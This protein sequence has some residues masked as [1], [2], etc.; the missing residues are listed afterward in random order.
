MICV[1][2]AAVVFWDIRTFTKVVAF[3]ANG[4]SDLEFGPGK[5]N[6]S[7]DGRYI[8]VRAR[9][10][11]KVPVAFVIDLATGTKFSDIDLSFLPGNNNYVSVSPTGRY[12]FAYQ[13]T[14][15]GDQGHI[16]TRDGI[17]VQH[18]LEHHRPGHGDMT[19]DA[20]G[21]DVM[22]GISKSDPDKYHVIKRRLRDGKVTDL[23]PGCRTLAQHVS[24]RNIR[25]PGWVFVT[26][27]GDKDYRSRSG[28]YPFYQSIAMLR[29]DGS[30]EISPVAQTRSI[31]AG[32]YSEAHGSPS[33]DG[34][35][36][37][38][39]SNWGVA[40]SWVAAYVAEFGVTFP[41]VGGRPSSSTIETSPEQVVPLQSSAPVDGPTMGDE[42]TGL[43][44]CPLRGFVP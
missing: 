15:F 38:F 20:D 25:R 43:D 23:T 32:Y 33:P 6:P 18:W 37:I 31:K 7:H 27:G 10:N 44:R 3:T 4:Y 12:L 40:D 2:E 9:R 28:Y 5:G 21:E 13:K 17:P 16:F 8:A 11:A 30:G 39:A 29:I 19:V 35:R 41:A 24:A 36:V 34:S 14:S 1:G 22:V 26:F 42:S